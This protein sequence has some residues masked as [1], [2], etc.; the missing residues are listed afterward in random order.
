MAE[1]RRRLTLDHPAVYRIEV[2]GELDQTWSSWFDPMTISCDCGLTTLV[3]LVA[4]QPQ[5]YGLLL[6]L[7]DLG[8]PLV[9][10][11]CIQADPDTIR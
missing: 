3:G 11:H 9:S 4:D 10:V 1:T 7:R 6:K 8:L 5:L 2:Q